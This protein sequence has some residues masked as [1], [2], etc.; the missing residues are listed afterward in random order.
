[1]KI[2]KVLFLFALGIFLISNASA[3]IVVSGGFG[4]G[5]QHSATIING[6]SI[7]FN[8]DFGTDKSPMTLSAKLYNSNG[9][10]IYSFLSTSVNGKAYQPTYNITPAIYLTNGSYEL[11]LTGTD[12]SKNADSDTLYLTVNPA[13][14]RD[15]ILPVITLLGNNTAIVQVEIPYSDAGATAF[16]NVDGAIIPRMISNNVDVNIR[17]AYSVIYRATDSS[18]NIATAT[19]TVDVV[20][21]IAPVISLNGANP[22][23][24]IQGNSYTEFG[25]VVTDNYDSGLIATINS[26]AVNINNIGSYQVT[27]NVVDSSG[28]PAAQVIR[29]VNVVSKTNPI[30]V[31][32][33]NSNFRNYSYIDVYQSQYAQQSNK[34]NQGINLTEKNNNSNS[35][36]GFAFLLFEILLVLVILGIIIFIFANRKFRNQ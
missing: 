16:D 19:R 14:T 35:S 11:V 9:N 15:T 33:G 20:D 17:G 24:I 3:T 8:A 13:S 23:T 22:L 25:A 12:N 31:P 28:N 18:G 27:Y 32:S 30:Y 21:T 34:V 29:T 26:S 10:V 4:T 7:I 1:M 6:Q 5:T 2:L 36:I